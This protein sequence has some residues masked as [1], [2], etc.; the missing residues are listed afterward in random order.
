MKALANKKSKPAGAKASGSTQVA[1]FVK[2]KL[3]A[4][5]APKGC[6]NVNRP[7]PNSPG[8]MQ[9]VDIPNLTAAECRA[10]QYAHP[11][12]ATQWFPGDCAEKK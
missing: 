11:G 3:P 5:A 8:G 6:C 10:I 2:S 1:R 4:A 9:S 12:T 7:D